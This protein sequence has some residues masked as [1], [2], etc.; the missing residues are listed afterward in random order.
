MV[1]IVFDY[2][3]IRMFNMKMFC[4]NV[5]SMHSKNPNMYFKQKQKRGHHKLI[6]VHV[7]QLNCMQNQYF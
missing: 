7:G 4:L 2:M 3:N 6:F 1:I 5:W